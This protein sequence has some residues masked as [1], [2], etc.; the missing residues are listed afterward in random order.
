MLGG[1]DHA[2]AYLQKAS[3]AP[4]LVL[5]A[6][7]MLFMDP[8]SKPDR[9]Q[10]DRWK[11]EAM[12]SSLRELGLRAWAPGLNDF[13]L[14]SA[15]LS[16]MTERGPALL[17]A[18]LGGENAG[19]QRTALY[20]VGGLRVGVAGISRPAHGDKKAEGVIVADPRAE[21]EKAARELTAQGAALRVALIALPRGEALRLIE[22]VP[23][24]QLAVLGK[25]SD[26]GDANDAPVPPTEIGKTLVVE[27]PNHLQG[28]YV[29]D[30]FVKDQ[31][32]EFVN[33]DRSSEQKAELD[34]RIAELEERIR[35]AEKSATV[36]QADLEARRKDLSAV[37]AERSKLDQHSAPPEQ[38]YYRAK[39]V[40]VRENLGTDPNV[41]LRLDEYYKQVNEHNRV[42]LKDKKPP[43]VPEGGSGFIGA[44]E[45][46]S[47]H[48][49]EQAFWSTTRHAHAYDT[50]ARQ[51][52]QFNLDCVGCHVTGYEEPGGSTVTFVDQL[53]DVQC[54]NCH[55]PGSR[56]AAKPT[57]K[58]LIVGTPSPTLCA[59][60]CHHPP[61]VKPD[62]N[63]GEAWLK[64]IGKGHGRGQ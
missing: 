34:R 30:W 44:K 27:G 32:F 22:A 18:N 26:Q 39:L 46:A 28:L 45:C 2:G 31:R 35:A 33:G 37:R 13:A 64:I 54:E 12:S 8:S 48:E 57:D 56:H 11:A 6:G 14:G 43:P 58:S 60:K 51:N 47:C 49:E 21:L 53:K 63:V 20:T 3:D 17:A 40:E 1:V 7:P 4:L 41:K 55:G 38:S 61:H 62:W 36:S 23:S 19:A 59:P 15:E 52:K 42:E 16:R 9:V 29:V 50:L 25:A 24:F 10:Q 5:G